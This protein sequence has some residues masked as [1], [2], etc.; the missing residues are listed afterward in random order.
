[1]MHGSSSAHEVDYDEGEQ[2]A[3]ST[4]TPVVS[5]AAAAATATV[6]NKTTAVVEA[7]EQDG[8]SG[9]GGGVLLLI[10]PLLVAGIVGALVWRRQK[11]AARVSYHR[12]GRQGKEELVPL[13]ELAEGDEDDGMQV[14]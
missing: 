5:S 8:S 2:Q 12:G 7:K 6:K 11:M 1:M 13:S 14:L 3:S 9:F 10:L 4:I